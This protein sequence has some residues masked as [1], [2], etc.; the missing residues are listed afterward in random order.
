MSKDY[1]YKLC[2]KEFNQKIDLAKHQSK[3]APCLSFTKIQH[4]S[5][6]K[7]VKTEFKSNLSIIFNYCF[8]VLRDNE[9]ITG[10]KALRT[11]AHLLNLRLLEPQFGNQ[12]DIDTYEYDFSSYENEIIEEHKTK[13]LSI[14][15][16]SNLARGKEKN[17]PKIMKCLWDEILS[18]HPI[19]KNIFLEGK[20]FDI[21]HQSTYKKLIN[22][23][24]TF[25]FEAVDEDILG[26]AYE[27]A[28]KDVRAARM[29]GQVFTPPNVKQMMIKLV[30]PQLKADGTI[31]KIFD[32]AM[33]TGG[34]LI[35]SL[36]HLLKQS[37]KK[38]YK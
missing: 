22:K 17:I 24:Y 2:K 26:E 10:I 12:I 3:K 38:E 21:Q 30:D 34:F 32:P 28:I 29:L 18:V 19:T 33:G 14:V 1:T 9:H 23:L 15:R 8:K 7:Q 27:E 4:N 6:T 5:Q 13:L 11:L 35:S 20:G 25:D 16:F 37:K 31:E 36:R